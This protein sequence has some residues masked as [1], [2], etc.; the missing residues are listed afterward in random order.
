MADRDLGIR[1]E[2]VLIGSA[3][4]GPII[5]GALVWLGAPAWIAILPMIPA[6]LWALWAVASIAT[7][8]PIGGFGLFVA[9]ASTFAWIV[10]SWRAGLVLAILLIALRGYGDA[11]LW[12]QRRFGWGRGLD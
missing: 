11:A 2:A 9:G 6:G 12:A 5:A 3:L 7:A 1:I 4:V 10:A 8:V